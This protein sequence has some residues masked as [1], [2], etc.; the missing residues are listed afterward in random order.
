MFIMSNILRRFNVSV[1]L[2]SL[3]CVNCEKYIHNICWL[4][5][6]EFIISDIFANMCFKCNNTLM[7]YVLADISS[8][9][10]V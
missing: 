5:L 6:D 7:G 4:S 8:R 1:K 10:V 3:L 9:H 2:H